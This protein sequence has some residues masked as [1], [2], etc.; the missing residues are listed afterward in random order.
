MC[1]SNHLRAGHNVDGWSYSNPWNVHHALHNPKVEKPKKLVKPRLP[2]EPTPMKELDSLK[3]IVAPTE[4]DIIYDPGCGD[5]RLL[6]ALCKD[7]GAKGV[8]FEINIEIAA[9][10]REKIK[11]AG[12]DRQIT[13]WQVDS[14]LVNTS[15]ATVSVMYLFPKLI[16]QLKFPNARLVVSYI[17]K[18]PDKVTTK[19]DDWYVHVPRKEIF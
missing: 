13:I 6:I 5:G 8:G 11:E 15:E 14:R 10:A 3:R 1:E 4:Q 17:H 2:F 19:I 12:L 9:L 16:K 7:S 18:I